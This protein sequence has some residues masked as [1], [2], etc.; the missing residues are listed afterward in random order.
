[1]NSLGR[2]GLV[3]CLVLACFVGTSDAALTSYARTYCVE[4]R[5]E[6]VKIRECLYRF[7]DGSWLRKE[8][9]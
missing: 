5:V 4:T 7:R 6:F 2:D 9:Y 1:M 8:G 3:L